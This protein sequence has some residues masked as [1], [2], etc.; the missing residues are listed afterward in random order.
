MLDFPDDIDFP[1][2]PVHATASQTFLV[3]NVGAA[4]AVFK[5]QAR[6]PFTVRP[7]AGELAP[8]EVLRCSADFCP[9]AAGTQQGLVA[10]S[11][12]RKKISGFKI[13]LYALKLHPGHGPSHNTCLER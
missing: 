1:A 2:T 10:T 13:W 5:L 12:Y 4:R 3:T 11:A 8:G 9:A 7:A 6:A